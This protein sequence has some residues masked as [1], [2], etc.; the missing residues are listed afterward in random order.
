MASYN[1]AKDVSYLNKDFASFRN[2]L[3]DFAK[4][5]F[6]ETY[7]DFSDASLGMM[8]IELVSYVGDVLSYNIDATLKE[9]MIQHAEERKNVIALAKTL[10]YKY[11]NTI[12]STSLIDVYQL[13]PAN[14]IDGSQIDYSYGFRIKPGMVV[15][16][17]TNPRMQFRTTEYVDFSVYNNPES[18]NDDASVYE[19]D[20]NG[21][22][23]LYLYKKSTPI[24]AGT[25]H[26]QQVVFTTPEKFTKIILPYTDVIEIIDI[27][28]SDGDVWYEVD[29]LAQD[30]VVIDQLNDDYIN[31][32]FSSD[33]QYVPTIL[34]YKKTAKRFTT[35]VNEDGNFEIQF[36]AGTSTQPDQILLPNE[37][38]IGYSTTFVSFIDSIQKTILSSTYGISPANTTLTVRFTRGGGYESNLQSNDIRTIV[39][40]DFDTNILD[41]S[42]PQQQQLLREVKD[43]LYVVNP[44]P[45]TGGRS[46]ETITEIRQNAIAYFNSQNRCVTDTDYVVRTLTMP[47]K[48]GNVAKA[49]VNKDPDSP[50]SINLYALGY[51][52]N[53]KL[54]TLSVS[55]K[56]NLKTYLSQYKAL[57]ASVN[58]KNAFII[59]I[60]VRFKIITYSNAN[61]NEV[62]VEC[63]RKIT[64]FFNIDLWQIGQPIILRDLYEVLDK[65]QGV[66][67][68]A[69][70]NVVNKYDPTEGYSNNYYNIP[71]ATKDGII[72]TSADPSIFELKYPTKDIEGR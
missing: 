11:R 18:T 21:N 29:F 25:L 66:R 16:S 46:S 24:I 41:F 53:K 27:V 36:G 56:Q 31:T 52:I 13:L 50:F 40:K 39:S 47:A 7:A 26:T 32:Q 23:T 64:D 68:V 35:T 67:T 17:I 14:G 58:I 71:S 63:I 10:G 19:V 34:K 5:H 20:I 22:P 2:N 60:G 49:F 8:F 38:T 9:T 54:T 65:V 1:I 15:S 61:K 55:G 48:Y 57:S 59:N 30:T 43:S 12:P 72:F 70:L 51:D 42:T 28:D 37:K 6:P 44:V 33:K 4:I 69:E 3:I 62:L 45:A